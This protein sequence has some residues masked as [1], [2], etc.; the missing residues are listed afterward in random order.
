MSNE[1]ERIQLADKQD[2]PKLV[3]I[4]MESA[5]QAISSIL[6]SKIEIYEPKVE[7]VS[8]NQVQYS[9]LEPVV[10]VK[11]C[12]TSNAA[13]TTMLV[14]RQRDVQIFLNELMGIDELPEPDFEFDEVALSA[15][16]EVMNQ[17]MKTSVSALAEYLSCTM[18]SADVKS[19]IGKEDQELSQV[20][21]EDGDRKVLSIT[22]K[23]MLQ[24]MIESEF[25]Q[26]LSL[27]AAQSICEKVEAKEEKERLESKEES[28]LL[29]SGKA[30]ILVGT[31]KQSGIIGQPGTARGAR[32]MGESPEMPY[33]SNINLI[34]DVP[35]NVSVEVGKT[36][37]KL[38]DILGFNNGT[39]VE[40]EKQAD[41]PAD[42]IVNGQLIA[43]GDV[44]VIDDNFGVRIT[45][46][47]NTKNIIGNGEMI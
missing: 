36:K 26:I 28:L 9:L 32:N 47:I 10:F 46:I 8:L 5:S 37:R 7:E 42:I 24:D 14:F 3:K 43:R 31:N 41:A 44:L 17:M 12:L 40:L 19:M 35:L 22:Y 38:K 1:P 30:D 21:G 16:N 29:A 20:F 13:G 6:K 2:F 15:T 25:I 45:E 4:Y 11:S 34:M 18:E 27:D 23:I 39:V 33:Q